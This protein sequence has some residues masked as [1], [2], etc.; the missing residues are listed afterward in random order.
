MIGS[1]PDRSRSLKRPLI[2]FSD[3]CEKYGLGPKS[4]AGLLKSKDAPKAINHA[5]GTTT[6][7]RS[8]FDDREIARFLKLKGKVS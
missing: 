3:A 4:L 5:G 7:A 2:L 6:P 1:Y 8:Y